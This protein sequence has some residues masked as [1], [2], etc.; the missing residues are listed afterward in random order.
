MAK[1]RELA[2]FEIAATAAWVAGY[3]H[4]AVKANATLDEAQV[5]MLRDKLREALGWEK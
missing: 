5:T 1:D 3:L 2:C 4:A